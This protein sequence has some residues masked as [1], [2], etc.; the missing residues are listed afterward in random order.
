MAEKNSKP[1]GRKVSQSSGADKSKP[2][3]TFS[4][5]TTVQ[6]QKAIIP[7][8]PR[9]ST[10]RPTSSYRSQPMQPK[11]MKPE[12]KLSSRHKSKPFLGW[13]NPRLFIETDDNGELVLNEDTKMFLEKI[14]KP[15]VV[16]SVVRTGKSFILNRLSGLGQGFSLGATVESTTKG[17]WI[18]VVPH[19]KRNDCRLVLI[20]TEGLGDM[21]K[22]KL[23]HDIWIFA[24]GILLSG[25]LVYNSKGAIDQKAMNDLHLVTEVAERI[26]V[27]S[28]SD[29]DDIAVGEEGGNQSSSGS[30]DDELKEFFP[31]FVW[32]LRDCTLKL[33]INGEVRSPDEY[34]EHALTA[35]TPEQG[36]D[37]KV[38]EKD[39]SKPI[40]PKDCI[41]EYFTQ[42]RC[43]VFPFPVKDT[44]L[45]DKIDTLEDCDFHKDFLKVTNEFCDYIFSESQ[46]KTIFNDITTGRALARLAA[47]YVESIRNGNAPCIQNA[48]EST[49]KIENEQAIKESIDLYI[50][51]FEAS[52]TFPI[53]D[54][55]KMCDCHA[56][57]SKE[58]FDFFLT[59][60]VFDSKRFYYKQLQDKVDETYAQ[61]L[62]TNGMKSGEA[63]E[64]QLSDLY[65][66]IAAKDYAVCGGYK[67]YEEDMER[68]VD[69]YEKTP[70]LKDVAAR[71]LKEFKE[72]KEESRKLI[73]QADKML[74]DAEK[75]KKELE[76]AQKAKEDAEK[77]TEEE[78]KKNKLLKEE[79]E[80]SDKE[81]AERLAAKDE[82]D[83]KIKGSD[84]KTGF[85]QT[86][87]NVGGAIAAS[88]IT[89]VCEAA[90]SIVNAYHK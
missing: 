19:P 53:K 55:K 80:K 31:S 37:L 56:K 20:D 12:S 78:Q 7:P 75:T 61:F 35:K 5:Q 47:I 83:R 18:W 49:R 15:V 69:T 81:L 58:A 44:D 33:E 38:S 34:L 2:P 25:T 6:K 64:K 52:V 40:H 21:D 23:D 30:K 4:Q 77:A 14:T 39:T 13:E 16:I 57:C 62:N 29:D 65:K 79:K 27:K 36:K 60:S 48:V 63:C 51:T 86:L 67:K 85:W 46:V 68:L 42:R 17:I 11:Q 43:F 90:K 74:S 1:S 8:T 70:H 82:E 45:M 32:T 87:Q 73:L 89:M 76:A 22:A 84:K 3:F 66:E 24:L 50:K 10:S 28:K 41:K 54:M 26:K 9:A 88:P 59:K 72:S 71:V